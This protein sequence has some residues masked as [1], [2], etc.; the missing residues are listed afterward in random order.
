M[1]AVIGK[2]M[3]QIYHEITGQFPPHY[4]AET[5]FAFAPE[6]KLEILKTLMEDKKL[7][8]FTRPVESVSYKD[9]C[10]VY[11]DQGWIIARFSGTEPLLRIFCEMPTREEAEATCEQLR[12]FL[13][14]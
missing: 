2:P 11:F 3:S 14:L 10:K 6:R 4:M 9:G 12:E 7:P 13:H 8:E 5:D 1:I